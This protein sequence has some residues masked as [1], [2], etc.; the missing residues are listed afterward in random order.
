MAEKSGPQIS[1][2]SQITQIIKGGYVL[3]DDWVLRPGVVNCF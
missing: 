1:Q 2:I 3:D